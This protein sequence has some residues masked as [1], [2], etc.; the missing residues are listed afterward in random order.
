MEFREDIVDIIVPFFRTEHGLA[1]LEIMKKSLK[2]IDPGFPYNL[3]IAEGQKPCVQNRNDGLRQSNTR[4][5]VMC[6]DDIIFKTPGWLKE[7][8]NAIKT[9]PE[10]GMVGFR[11]EDIT[12]KIINAGRYIVQNDNKNFSVDCLELN[13]GLEFERG[14]R[15]QVAGCLVLVDR[16]VAG[17]YPQNIYPGKVNCEDVDYMMTIQANGYLL[18][19]LG[20]VPVIHN[21][22]TFKE[23]KEKYQ[24]TDQDMI[25]HLIFASRWNIKNGKVK[26]ETGEGNETNK[27]T[28]NK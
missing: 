15:N 16:L 4:Y 11:T 6:D 7:A 14:L 19:Y 8:M 17:Y 22:S 3:I 9:I 18:Y 26:K 24:L 21:E 1:R 10:T 2:E 13:E 28:D 23:K 12:G 27:H 25:N 5:F 20:D